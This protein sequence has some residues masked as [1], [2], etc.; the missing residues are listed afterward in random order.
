MLNSTEYFFLFLCRTI[1]YF[2]KVLTINFSVLIAILKPTLFYLKTCL[3]GLPDRC[4]CSNLVPSWGHG[5]AG[6][7]FWP[8]PWRCWFTRRQVP[9]EVEEGSVFSINV[10]F[11][12]MVVRG[13]S[14][15][16]DPICFLPLCAVSQGLSVPY[17]VLENRNEQSCTSS[18]DWDHGKGHLF[19]F[20]SVSPFSDS[21]QV[22]CT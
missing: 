21:L 11:M 2:Y 8:Q 9:S 12:S 10:S 22:P 15:L 3:H 7:A 4:A 16:R 19:G 17:Q 13:H 18:Q 1:L 5:S 14:T 6:S 20:P